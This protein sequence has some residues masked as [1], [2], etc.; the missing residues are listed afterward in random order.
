MDIYFSSSLFNKDLNKVVDFVNEM[1]GNLEISRFGRLATVDNEFEDVL[2]YY[3][4]VLKRLKGKLS[5]HS[6]FYD[7][8]PASLDPKIREF[9]KYRY[10]QALRV[11]KTLNAQTI[12]F[13]T[14]YN[15]L[16][17]HADYH[18]DFFG[19]HMRF[20][21]EFV[22]KLEEAGIVA[23][24]E[25]TCEDKPELLNR[26]VDSIGSN[27]L[28]VC[29]DTGH[30]N[31]NSDHALEHWI[32]GVGSRLHHMHVHNNYGQMDEH[33]SILD[34]TVDFSS[35]VSILE[36]ESLSPNLV[37]EIFSKEAALE[38]YDCIKKQFELIKSH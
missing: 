9:V 27:N 4:S 16:V 22:P 20:W 24:V 26:I 35:F 18:K 13:H 32:N 17:K 11:A 36:R 23:V 34:G 2:A 7:L 38:S 25:N 15:G 33:N 6:F 1:S 3:Q 21:S 31:L 28:K 19:G 5:L 37:L 8:N 14:G 10:S 30:A 12:V 29:I